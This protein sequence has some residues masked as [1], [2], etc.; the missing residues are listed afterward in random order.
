MAIYLGSNKVRLQEYIDTTEVVTDAVRFIDYDG[1]ILHEYSKDEFLALSSMPSNP[2]H[3]GLI[4]Q[5]WNWSLSDAKAYVNE[6]DYLNI[7][8]MYI[9]ESGDTEIDVEFPEGSVRLSPY[10]GI[11]VK[12]EVDID[13]G[14]NSTHSIV[15]GTRL[16]NQIRTQHTYSQPGNYTIKIHVNSGSF[17]FYGT[18]A[19]PLLNNN[20]STNAYYNI[21]YSSKV[22]S[23]RIGENC[24]IGYFA[25]NNCY[26]L[27]SITIPDGVTSIDGNAFQNCYSLK[28]IT[29][30]DTVTSIGSSAFQNCYSLESIT[31]PDTV[32]SIGSSAFN[33]CY[34]LSS[35]T[36]PS[37][38]TSI[39]DNAFNGCYSIKIKILKYLNYI[40]NF[41]EV[42]IPDS[43]TSIDNSAFQ[44]CYSL[45]SITIPDTV[46]S[47]G[48][49][50]FNNCYS[51][52]SIKIPEGVTSIGY[53]SFSNCYS[54]QSITIPSN[55][56]SIDNSTFQNCY[57]L[58]SI[59]IPDTVTSISS[60]TFACCYSLNSITI[61]NSITSIGNYAFQYCY[62]LQSITI[63]N[64]VTSIGNN[65]FEGCYS[66]SSI[67]IPDT[68]TSIGSSAFSSCYGMKEI[69]LKST[70]PPSLSS[71]NVFLDNPSDCI[72]YVPQGTLST[73]QSATNWS[74]Y[75][76]KMQEESN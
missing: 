28:S 2:T 9:T 65:A 4:S 39:G 75:A 49:S 31:I 10:L 45:K 24:S 72:F 33:S 37:T 25:F 38:V 53:T 11:A 13:W 5:G 8:Q 74:T 34:S 41:K 67:T 27:N 42:I 15:T 29:I 73:Y 50:A 30:P 48:S 70:T 7:G 76:S 23:I 40:N 60:Y 52:K 12:N 58:Q 36:I 57:S 46:T 26:S 35:I 64:S 1:T 32:T 18:Y 56:H 44:Y 19:Y 47:I 69:H 14:D 22:K 51:L 43:V 66:L 63:P 71:T 17:A 6:K 68:V 59:T 16:F 21:I 55:V 54:L 61:P 3:S 20:N 62:S